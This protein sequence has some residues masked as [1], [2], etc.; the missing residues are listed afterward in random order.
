MVSMPGIL[1]QQRRDIRQFDYPLADGAIVVLHTD[2]LTDRWDLRG[3][4]ALLD[5]MP[6]LIAATLLR[7]AGKRRDD[8]AVLVAKRR[9]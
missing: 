6:L 5:H 9:Q 7:D 8:A 3:Y 4:P 2:G 1:G